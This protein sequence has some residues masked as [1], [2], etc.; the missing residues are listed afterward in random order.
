MVW[1]RAVDKQACLVTAFTWC[2]WPEV[3]RPPV[4]LDSDEKPSRD[5]YIWSLISSIFVVM[6]GRYVFADAR[7]ASEIHF[8]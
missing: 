7:L 4:G 3:R 6:C 2:P 5:N 1:D 8:L